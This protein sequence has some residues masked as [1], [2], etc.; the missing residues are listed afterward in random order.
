MPTLDVDPGRGPRR[1]DR[2]HSDA[3]ARRPLGAPRMAEHRT[4]KTPRRSPSESPAAGPIRDDAPV[5]KLTAA[6][7]TTRSAWAGGRAVAVDDPQDLR[8]AELGGDDDARLPIMLPVDRTGPGRAVERGERNH[9]RASTI[10]VIKSLQTCYGLTCF[11]QSVH[12]CPHDARR[13][14]GRARRGARGRRA[15]PVPGTTRACLPKI[16]GEWADHR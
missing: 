5:M 10:T 1:S 4:P 16:G 8:A 9:V 15:R 7:S 11:R 6:T 13:D 12:A 14:T 2:V 3:R